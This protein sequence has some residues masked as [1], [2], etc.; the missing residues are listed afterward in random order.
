MAGVTLQEPALLDRMRSQGD[1]AITGAMMAFLVIM[2]VPLPPVMLDMLL[3]TSIAGGLLILLV[4]FYVNKPVQFS[5]FPMLLLG[6]T[7]FRLSLNI[8]STRLILL[9]GA[10]GPDAAGNI[11]MTFG[12]VVV[13]GS[14][15]V[16][17]VVFT[18]LVVINFMVVTKGAGRV[19]EVAARFT[20]DAMPG[21]QMAIDAE[22]NAGL[23]DEKT[24][25]ARRS[26]ITREADFYGSMDGASKFIRGDAI[27]GIIITLVNIVG[28]L[29][30]GLVEGGLSFRD[31]LELYTVLTIGDGLVGQIPALIISA[32]AG[33]LVTRV[34]DDNDGGNLHGQLSGQLLRAQRPLVLLSITLLGFV[35]MPGLRLPFLLL[36]GAAGYTAWTIHQRDSRVKKGASAGR[37]DAKKT[38]EEGKKEESE[39]PVEMLLRVEPLAIELGV[40]LLSLVDERKGGDLVERIQRIRRQIVQD[41]GLLVPSV[42]LRDNLRLDSGEY[43]I[44]LRGEEIGRGKVIPRKIL[45]INPG[46]ATARMKGQKTRDPVFGLEGFWIM[47]N[48]RLKAQS[49]RYTVVDIPTILTTHLTELLHMNGHELFGRQQLSNTLD[50]VAEEN[51]RLIEDL[52]PEL[53]SRSTAL[54]VFRNLLREGIS[55]RDSQTIFEAL[56]D[57]AVKIKEPDVLT[58]FVRQRLARH[59]THRFATPEGEIHYIGLAPDA[60]DA[61]SR[62]LRTE[63]GGVVSLSMEPDDARKMLT[64]LK[65]AAESWSGSGTVVVL[66]PPL[67]RGPLRRLAEKIIPRVPILSPGELLPAVRLQRVAT[68]SLRRAARSPRSAT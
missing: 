48:Q 55:V 27:A 57:H 47:E 30:M 67:A 18:I 11:I 13:G 53:I 14:Y 51:P 39:L 68:V 40:E 28:G 66:C 60:E 6:T 44:L 42:H 24:A 8:A 19:A 5:V 56:A 49:R 21:K 22:M 50:R 20:L 38:G 41:L 17:M 43:R 29:I 3:A 61:L 25:R 65:S 54:R 37:K 10:E 9:H 4:T 35:L 15:V 33:I 58:E 46:D 64:R 23:I 63:Q 1:I 45:A 7:L 34:S 62:G 12:N 2:I 26:E 59:I 52:I 31:A 16:G 32:A 36:S